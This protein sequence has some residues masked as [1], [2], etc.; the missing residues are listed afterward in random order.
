[1]VSVIEVRVVVVD[2]VRVSVIESTGRMLVA[3]AVTETGDG[4][5]VVVDVVVIVEMLK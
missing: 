3:V 2:S 5:K 4:V 1:M